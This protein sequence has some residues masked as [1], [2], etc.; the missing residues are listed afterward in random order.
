MPKKLENGNYKFKR[1]CV[2]ECDEKGNYKLVSARNRRNMKR[3]IKKKI[4]KE[5]DKNKNKNLPEIKEDHKAITQIKNRR[6][7]KKVFSKEKEKEKEINAQN[8]G[9]YSNLNITVHML[10]DFYSKNF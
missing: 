5:P 7:H 3:K 10:R 4:S 1:G 6:S 9:D 2:G 8:G